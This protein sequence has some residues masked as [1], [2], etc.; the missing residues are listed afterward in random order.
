MSTRRTFIS[1]LAV[2]AAVLIGVGCT[3][4]EDQ[5]NKALKNSGVE[6]DG[7]GK[8]VPASL[9]KD[10]VALPKLQLETAI[11]TAGQYVFRYT[12]PDPA[13]DVAGYQAALQATGFTITGTFDN[14]ADP[15][16]GGNVGFTAT[17]PRWSVTVSAFAKGAV[18]GLYM[19]VVVAPVSG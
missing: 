12:S 8:S 18:D 5:V 14:L 1:A 17:G 10:E 2:S 15:A 11:G 19:G 7:L 13:G 3:S 16:S 4:P 6:L 9:P